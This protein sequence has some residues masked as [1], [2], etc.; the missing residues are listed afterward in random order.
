MHHL[1]RFL[2]ACIVV[3][4]GC[5]SIQTDENLDADWAFK[6]KMAVRNATEASSVN[7]TWTQL[8]QNYDIELSGPLG[9]GSVSV[10]G[11]PGS[12]TMTQGSN[13]YSASTL[14]EL[15]LATTNLDLPLDH[16]QYWVRGRPSPLAPYSLGRNAAEQV[17]EINQADW[18]VNISEYFDSDSPLP[19]RLQ[20]AR[21]ENIGKLVIREWTLPTLP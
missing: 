9:Q 8:N 20:F 6:G 11:R 13:N 18:L 10:V 17:I 14:S 19:R 7:V 1:R 16:L 3:L 21:D 12:V 5:A 2:V 15:V 4:T